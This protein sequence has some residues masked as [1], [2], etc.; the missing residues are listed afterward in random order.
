MK[1]W[2]GSHSGTLR[3][4]PHSGSQRQKLR[5]EGLTHGL[6]DPAKREPRPAKP[7]FGK[8]CIRTATALG[9]RMRTG[10]EGTRG[11]LS[12]QG[13]VLPSSGARVA[14][15]SMN[16]RLRLM[17]FTVCRFA[18]EEEILQIDIEREECSERT[19]VDDTH[20]EIFR[21]KGTNFCSLL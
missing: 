14:Q 7:T 9:K 15:N 4:T 8:L 17:H 6:Q 1:T 11:T 20:A 3:T 18:S 12:P 19:H 10:Q 16:V 5:A 13:W 2:W 21:R